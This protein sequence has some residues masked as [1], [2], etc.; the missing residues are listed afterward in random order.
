MA[1]LKIK[2]VG[3]FEPSYQTKGAVGADIYSANT[4]SIFIKPNQYRSVPTDLHLE[5]PYGYEAQIRPRSGLA[6]NFGIGI[7][8]SPGTIDAD[9]RGEIQVVLFNFS[10]KI[11]VVKPKMRIAQLIVSKVTRPRF[12]KTKNLKMTKRANGGFGHTGI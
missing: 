2:Y 8:N 10:K 11:F 9:Y 7:L 1:K 5:L 6:R 3:K 4:K 12:I